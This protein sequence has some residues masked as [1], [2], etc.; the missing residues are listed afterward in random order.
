MRCSNARFDYKTQAKADRLAKEFDKRWQT[1]RKGKL[2]FC[3][4]SWDHGKAWA[5]V[6]LCEE[7]I[8]KQEPPVRVTREGSTGASRCDWCETYN[9]ENL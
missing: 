9:E 5:K 2:T 7:C 1:R 4:V 6:V 8:G 3:R